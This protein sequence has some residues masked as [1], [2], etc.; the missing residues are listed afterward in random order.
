LKNGH[1]L[2]SGN[3]F[4]YVR[5]VDTAGKTVW[6][7]T[8]SELPQYPLYTVQE[9]DRLANGNTLI[10]NWTASLAPA[11]WPQTIQ[12][13]VVTPAKK[14][15]W[16]LSDWKDLG[17]ASATQLLDEPGVPEKHGLQR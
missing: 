9:V 3:Q 1:T 2:I 17:P 12:L 6:E 11:S 8:R 16:A 15:V 13:L 14:V 7:L 5:E 10:N 4:G